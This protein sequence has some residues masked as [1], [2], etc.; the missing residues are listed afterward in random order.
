MLQRL[1]FIWDNEDAIMM[2][3][4]CELDSVD[5]TGEGGH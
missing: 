4:Y 1:R 3:T 5:P 2:A